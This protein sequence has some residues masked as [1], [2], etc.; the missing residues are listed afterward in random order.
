MF[1]DSDSVAVE[2]GRIAAENSRRA[3]D[4]DPDRY[5][6]WQPAQMF[7]LEGRKR[8]A[9]K[10]LRKAGVFPSRGEPVLE[11][12]CGDLGWMGDLISWGLSL[13]DIHGIDLEP[14]RVN[15]AREALPNADIR[16]GW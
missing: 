5:A 16:V 1:D 14:S 9:V 11:V 8:A 7:M 6:S 10:L 12:G 4:T 15:R 2:P 13:E 3:R